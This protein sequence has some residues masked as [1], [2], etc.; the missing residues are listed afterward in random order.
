ML[1]GRAVSWPARSS[2]N[3]RIVREA[4]H[5]TPKAIVARELTRKFPKVDTSIKCTFSLEVLSRGQAS[6]VLYRVEE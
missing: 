1:A 2:R 5:T 6:L 3:V 4:A